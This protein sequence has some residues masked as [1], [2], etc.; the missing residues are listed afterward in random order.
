MS[1]AAPAPGRSSAHVFDRRRQ[2][3]AKRQAVLDTASLLF[4]RQGYT[5]TTLDDLAG[6]MGLTKAALYYYV[7]GKEDLGV[8]AYGRTL[9]LQRHHLARAEAAGG[10]GLDRLT[11]YIGQA[12]DSANPP[13]AIVNEAAALKQANRAALEARARENAHRMRGF[14]ARGIADGSM[15]RCDPA[16][17]GLALNGALSWIPQWYSRRT[18]ALEEIGATFASILATG[19]RAP[20]GRRAPLA[21]V[22]IVPE[23][24]AAGIF[25]REAQARVKREALLRAATE[26]F[27][28]KG[29]SGTTLEEVVRSLNVTKGAFYYYVKSKDDLLFRCYERGYRMLLDLLGRID[30]D[31]LDGWE[32]VET[33]LR[34]TIALHCGASGPLAIFTGITSL[35]RARRAAV[36]ALAKAGNDLFLRFFREGIADGSIR[37]CDPQHAYGAVV[38]ALVWLPKWYTPDGAQTPDRIA[39]AFCDLFADGLA[40]R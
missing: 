5:G 37:R 8:Q 16:L 33:A 25:D 26:F 17:A 20:A 3:E 36:A 15:R 7:S 39:D 9:D 40:V 28:R 21:A 10:T 1:D 19:L 32:K 22:E 24:P 30:A 13:S 4:N 14:I 12:C 18:R 27:N 2:H 31:D 6:R 34:S 23:R 11:R 38:G 35:S 29:V